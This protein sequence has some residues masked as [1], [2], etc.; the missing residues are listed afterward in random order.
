MDIAVKQK[1]RNGF[2]LVEMLIVIIIIAIIAVMPFISYENP[3]VELQATQEQMSRDMI[4][5]QALSMNRGQRYRFNLAANNYSF[6][7]EAGVPIIIPALNNSTNTLPTDITIS[8]WTNLPNNYVIFD[9][10]GIPYTDPVTTLNSNAVITI[11]LSTGE[12][13]TITITPQTGL[14]TAN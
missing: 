5:L 12:T 14:V 8:G 2:T 11:L 9:G 6:S 13:K 7:T 3:V 1:G 4:F 10:R